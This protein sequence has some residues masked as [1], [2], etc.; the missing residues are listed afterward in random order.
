VS[1]LF[2]EDRAVMREYRIFLSDES[3]AFGH[4]RKIFF[5]DDDAALVACRRLLGH[6]SGID[7]WQGQRRVALLSRADSLNEL[8][9][10]A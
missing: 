1:E 5:M 6:F 4:L 2:F 8:K 7:I 9:R 10:P 3:G